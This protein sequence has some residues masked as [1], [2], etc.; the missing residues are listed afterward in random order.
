MK[1]S[2]HMEHKGLVKALKFLADS[3]VQVE[4]LITDRHKQIAR[5]MREQKP[6]IDH[7]YDLWHVSKGIHVHISI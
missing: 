7:C 6:S 3:S 5:Y 4:T 1:S 2:T